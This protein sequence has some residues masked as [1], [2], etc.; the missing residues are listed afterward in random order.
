MG[1]NLA[2]VLTQ[3]AAV[4]V[5][6]D[7]KAAPAV[8]VLGLTLAVVAVHMVGVAV[9]GDVI[10]VDIMEVREPMEFYVLSSQEHW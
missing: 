2:A 9:V 10:T 1:Q 4:V 8:V 3:V 5:V 7:L 6:A